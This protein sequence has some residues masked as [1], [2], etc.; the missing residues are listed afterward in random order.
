MMAYF[1]HHLS[2]NYVDLSDPYVDLSVISVDLSDNYFDIKN[3]S[4][5]PITAIDLLF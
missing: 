5:M 3:F 1:C 4:T 2:D